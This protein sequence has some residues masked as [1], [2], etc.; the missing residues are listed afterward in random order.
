[1]TRKMSDRTLG[2]PCIAAL[3]AGL[4]LAAGPASADPLKVQA[5]LAAEA[6]TPP[7]TSKG[8]GE[9]TG[10]FDPASRKLSYDV[11]YS[12]LTGAA[13]AAHFHAPAP[14]GKSAGVEV[15]VKGALESPIKGEATLTT[16]EAR[17]L[18]EGMTYFNI[19]T[20]ANKAGEIRGQVMVVK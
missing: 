5:K 13:T 14:V 1:M 17:N 20:A 16:E 3:A 7:N 8:A 15:P 4:L 19:H 11:S 9:L 2:I 18:T 12:G 6:E 10:T